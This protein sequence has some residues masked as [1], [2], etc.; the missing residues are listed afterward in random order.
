LKVIVFVLLLSATAWG[1]GGHGPVFGYA[2]PVNSQGEWSVDEGMLLRANSSSAD[3]TL[4]SMI[5]Y[6]FTPHLTVWAAAPALLERGPFN[7]TALAGGGDFTGKAAWRFHHHVKSVGRR[8]ETTASA[9]LVVAGPQS[10]NLKRAAG[11]DTALV[12]GMAS[13]SHY[14]WLG[15]GYRRFAERGGDQRPDVLSY[16]LVYGYRPPSWRKEADSWDWRL[17]AEMTGERSGQVRR[18]GALLPESAAHQVFLGPSTLGIYHQFAV[19]AGVQFPVYQAVGAVFPRERIRFA[20]NVS[21]FLF[22]AH[23]H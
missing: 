11:L 7:S 10:G 1:Q 20:I 8:F 5:G 4:R 3:V 15:G 16:S 19:E 6:G 14:A 13:R 12:S 9:G 17:F 23:Q 22:Q 21:Y 2:T 18:A